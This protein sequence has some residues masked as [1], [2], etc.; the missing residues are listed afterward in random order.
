MTQG[1]AG[2]A[3]EW[4]AHWRVIVP[5]FLGIMLCS[6]HGHALGVMI[7]PLEA[8]FGWARAQI[9]AGFLIISIMAIVIS[10]FVGSAVDRFG[11]RRIALVGVLFYCCTLAMLSLA[12]S[13]VLSWWALWFFLALGNMTIMPVVWL[14]VING[15]FLRSR[16]LAMAIALSGTGMG[17]AIF[18]ILTNTL[19][20]A[21][22]WRGA[23]VALAAISAA[24]VFPVTLWLF[25]ARSGA[26]SPE[27]L[28]GDEAL[29]KSARAQMATPRFWKLAAAAIVFAVAACALTNN[30]V[31]VL[32]GEGLT[33][34]RAAATAG[35][36][37]IGSITGRLVGGYLLDRLDGNKVAAVSV[38]LPIVPATILLSTGQSLA[39]ASAACVIMGFSVGAE[40]DC[41][42]Y[43]AA[44]HFG[45]RNFGVLFGSINGMLLFGNGL[46]PLLANVVYDQTRSY[47]LVLMG[48]I[49]LFALTAILF[50]TLGRYPDLDG[51][52]EPSADQHGGPARTAPA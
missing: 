52:E 9:S 40:L 22:G 14:A 1:T 11:A 46:A 42:A 39:W 26:A 35:L 23:Y 48:L 21:L 31:P 24:I 19:V 44:R 5:A 4:R 13:N 30:M 34:A 50:L 15:Y 41:C 33:P 25:R 29:R 32:I 20:D 28:A 10:P 3:G 17:A 6:A 36:L 12:G 8:E 7:R 51:T 2:A 43:L 37:G 49:P 27:P 45:T 16:G 47:D 38:L 18:P